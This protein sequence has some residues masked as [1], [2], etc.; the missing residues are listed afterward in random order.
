LAQK[1][2]FKYRFTM[3]KLHK[4]KTCAYCAQPGASQTGDHVVARSFVV[5][6]FRKEIPIVPACAACN[7]KKAELEHYAAS[8]LP[9]GG[10]HAGAQ[11]SL[12]DLEKRLAKNRR[13]HRELAAGQT[14]IWSRE[15]G[16]MMPCLSIPI[17]GERLEALVTY[18]VRGLL[19]HHW[20]VA[21]GSDYSAEAYSLTKH[22]EQTFNRYLSLN[23]AQRVTGDIGQGAAIYRGVQAVDDPNISMWEV[24]LFGGFK[25][26]GDDRKTTSTRFGAMTGPLAVI[27]RAESL[28]ANGL[29]VPI[30]S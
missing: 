13:L 12:S 19:F 1:T 11:A 22:G 14:R 8:I 6:A 2:F 17:D 4:G 29:V 27:Q 15:A 25:T 20:G 9:F 21:L 23:S 7:G 18:V 3:S 28:V 30:P 5:K 16:L 10:R 26:V 24:V